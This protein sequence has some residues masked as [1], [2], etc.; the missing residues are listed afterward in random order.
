MNKFSQYLLRL[1][2][3]NFIIVSLFVIMLQWLSSAYGNL[4]ILENAKYTAVDF[5]VVAVYGI[6]LVINLLI[7]MVVAVS[8]IMIL[9]IF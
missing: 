4:N 3:K 8:F 2:L 1:F 7:A 5:I 9:V 6:V